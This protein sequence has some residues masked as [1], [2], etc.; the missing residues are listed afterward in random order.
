MTRG[1]RRSL[2]LGGLAA[3]CSPRREGAPTDAPLPPEHALLDWRFSGE[4]A[5]GGSERA[6][7]LVPRGEGPFPVLI[8][9][10]GRG[11]AVRGA[12]A[13]AYGWLRDY[14]V[15]NAVQAL[16]R[17][18]LAEADFLGF[19]S[20]ERLATLNASL[21]QAPYRG[22]ILL[23]PHAPDFPP[24]G[25]EQATEAY[26]RWLVERLLPR[27]RQS[28][29]CG[30]A[31]IDGVS[32]GGRIALSVGLRSPGVFQA[33]GSLQAAIKADEAPALGKLARGYLDQRPGG[34]IRLLSSEGDYFR[35][36]I[37][38]AHQALDQARAPHEHLVVRGPHDYQFNQG[39][40]SIE[41]LLWH[42]RALR[43]G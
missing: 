40:G 20:P 39:P 7:A 1:G 22:L 24:A 26:G 34:K 15:G 30:A 31:G 6:T 32:M 23:C 8:A 14:R 43:A 27:A 35:P 10:H 29:P 37:E 41:M 42:D 3:A 19:V 36:A 17:G 13:G 25:R 18:S 11:E 4:Q 12:E 2:L 38:A 9:L 33:V 5:R 21:R 28:A 16:R